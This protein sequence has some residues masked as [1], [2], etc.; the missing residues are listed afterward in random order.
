MTLDTSQFHGTETWYKFNPITQDVL[1]DGTKYV[2]EQTD[3]FGLMM[4]ISLWLKEPK[5]NK[6]CYEGIVAIKIDTEKEQI[7]FEDGNGNLLKK[8][9][10]WGYPLLKITIWAAMLDEKTKV[11]MLPSEY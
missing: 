10:L 11:L 6:A 9:K 4:D 3:N 7:V 2:A 1:T 8:T 5:L